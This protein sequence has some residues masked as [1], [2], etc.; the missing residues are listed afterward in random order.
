VEDVNLA[1]RCVLAI[2]LKGRESANRSCGLLTPEHYAN[3]EHA[4]LHEVICDLIEQPEEF[5]ELDAMLTA[6]HLNPLISSLAEITAVDASRPVDIL[7]RHKRL[8]DSRSLA[9]RLHDELSDPSADPD[10][11][12]DRFLADRPQAAES[13]RKEWFREAYQ[14][15][16]DL[17]E[18]LCPA[19]STGFVKLDAAL[20]GGFRAGLYVLAARPAVGK[21]ALALQWAREIA[22]RGTPADVV[23][24]EMSPTD[25]AGRMLSARAG[26]QKPYERSSLK[27]HPDKLR[28]AAKALAALPI[29]FMDAHD[30]TLAALR[31]FLRGEFLVVDYLQLMDVPGQDVRALAVGEIS[32]T[33]KR[34]SLE[35]NIPV[36]ALSQ[37]NRQL[38]AQKREPVLADLRESGSIEQDADVVMLMSPTED[39]EKVK[40]K[41]AKNRS[42]PHEELELHFDK[43]FGRFSYAPGKLSGEK[44]VAV[45]SSPS[46]NYF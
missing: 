13:G 39:D 40:L 12:I 18:G 4:E 34:I 29:R 15:F 27:V 19:V 8:L 43:P 31:R 9:N 5:N 44:P 22:Q 25:C 2:A 6:P 20:N 38:E 3:P 45:A 46:G 41:V 26:A 28:E 42:G 30:A 7:Q 24:L 21:S 33:L 37:L 14:E 11:A 36:L 17:N 16:I 10:Q 1:E 32:R 35:K 23:S